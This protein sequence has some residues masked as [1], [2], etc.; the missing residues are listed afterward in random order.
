MV[1]IYLGMG[2]EVRRMICGYDWHRDQP[3]ILYFHLD[4]N[5]IIIVITVVEKNEGVTGR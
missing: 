2:G 5:L 4:I 1:N 3:R